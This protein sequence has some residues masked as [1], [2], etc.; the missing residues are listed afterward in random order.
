MS[1]PFRV[2]RAPDG[3]AAP[4]SRVKSADQVGR[5]IR[6]GVIVEVD[7]ET[8]DACGAWSD[9][10]LT[11]AEAFEAAEDPADFGEG[12]GRDNGPF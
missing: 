10:C 6:P 11:A 8:A 7:R 3:R 1:R 12:G 5:A 9:D 4:L 2:V